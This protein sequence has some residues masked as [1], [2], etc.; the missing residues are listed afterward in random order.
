MYLN[1]DLEL[2]FSKNVTEFK[3]ISEFQKL[4]IYFVKFKQTVLEFR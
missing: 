4:I 3:K 2:E 1:S